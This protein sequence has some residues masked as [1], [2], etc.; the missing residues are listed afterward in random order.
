VSRRYDVLI[1]GGGMVGAALA[2]L[3]AR[4]DETLAIAVLEAR[5]TPPF[6]PNQPFGVRVSAISRASMR[7][8]DAC[9]AWSSIADARVSPYR[10]MRVWDAQGEAFGGGSVHF[11][12][13]DLG[14]PDLGA[15]VENDLIQAM[16]ARQLQS[17]PGVTWMAPV[18]LAGLELTAAEATAEL[19]DGR[20]LRA[21]LVVGADGGASA[22]R[23]LAGIGV[24]GRN[25]G[26][27]AVV[28]NLRCEQPHRE[29]AWQRFLPT[30]P[31][32]FLPLSDGRCSIVWSTTPA[33]AEELL[34]ME[35]ADFRAAVADGAGGVMG[36]ITESSAPAAFPL[37]MQAAERYTGQRLALVGDAAHSVHPLAGQGVNLGFLD[38]AALAQVIAAA[39]ADGRDPGDLRALRRYERWRKGE[40]LAAMYAIDTIGRLFSNDS[41]TLGNLRRVGLEF[42]DAT[43]RLKNE[44]IRRAMGVAGDLPEH[45]RIR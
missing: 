44:F 23:S 42:V 7:I 19:E 8:L 39:V 37:R 11:D 30:G 4:T 33:H 32:A 21:R 15:I 17:I 27:H 34:A 1:V 3:L 31:L 29:T 2:S 22:T 36:E 41:E 5:E 14:E 35:P 20:R 12:S 16:L 9:G 24:T 25:Y 28:A 6:D 13:A 10:E 38:A 18:R 43:P 45:A 26:Q 40:N